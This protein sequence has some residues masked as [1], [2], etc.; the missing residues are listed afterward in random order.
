MNNDPIAL[1]SADFSSKHIDDVLHFA[2]AQNKRRREKS[3]SGNCDGHQ[4][5]RKFPKEPHVRP[6][7]EPEVIGTPT[8]QREQ[9]TANT[10]L[11]KRDE[12]LSRLE[13]SG[14][15]AHQRVQQKEIYGRDETGRKSQTT[16]SPSQ[17]VGEQPI[18]KQ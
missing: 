17:P 8:N 15:P 13:P 14:V 4:Q 7:I 9:S 5:C 18:K 1:P 11:S 16:V 3:S 10:N 12:H 6:G 2:D